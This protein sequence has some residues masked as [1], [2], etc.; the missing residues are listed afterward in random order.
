MKV[1]EAR[2]PHEA[3]IKGIYELRQFGIPRSSR[4]GPVLVMP[5]P[6]TTIYNF[7]L[8][9]VI[10]WPQRDANPFFHLYE[11]L[12]MLAGRNRVEPLVRYAKNMAN[13]A[14]NGIIHGAYGYRWRYDFGMDQ[15]QLIIKR[16]QDDP[17]DRRCVLQ[18]WDAKRDL[19]QNFKDLPCNTIVSFQRDI[20]GNLDMTVFCRSNDIIWGAYGANAVHFSMLQEYIARSIGCQMGRYY[21]VSVNWHAYTG[22]L[23]KL[24][25]LT[26]ITNVGLYSIPTPIENPYKAGVIPTPMPDYSS[27]RLDRL[28][29]DLLYNADEGF[30]TFPDP[31]EDIHAWGKVV[32]KVLRAHHIYKVSGDASKA[33]DY[34]ADYVEH[35]F[36]W[37]IAAT[38]WLERRQKKHE[39]T[40]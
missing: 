8:E 15:L 19:N 39:N 24:I 35:K 31:I 28:I 4:N 3:L 16:L 34:L 38:Q 9:R 1:I 36:D 13:Y 29:R 11:S 20:E 25:G 12:W 30:P 6:V 7:P 5:T 32:Y 22:V 33:I 21:Q 27:G 10:F 18:I 17:D 37:V 26:E 40:K 14:D 23:D 2:N